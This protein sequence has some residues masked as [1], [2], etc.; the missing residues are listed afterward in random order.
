[1]TYVVETAIDGDIEVYHID[2]DAF[3]AERSGHASFVRDGNL[4]AWFANVIAVYVELGLEPR[5]DMDA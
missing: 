2:A 5:S 4:V 1:M 3:E